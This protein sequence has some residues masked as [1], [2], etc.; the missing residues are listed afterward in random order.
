[1]N[2]STRSTHA[3]DQGNRINLSNTCTRTTCARVDQHRH[4]INMGT[5]NTC[6][7]STQEQDKHGHDIINIGREGTQA[8]DQKEA[9]WDQHR[10]NELHTK[11]VQ[12]HE[13]QQGKVLTMGA[14][15]AQSWTVG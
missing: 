9:T 12:H 11:T 7:G 14:T 8:W 15:Q 13:K 5:R 4:G 1:M 3:W 6:T 2:M 10:H